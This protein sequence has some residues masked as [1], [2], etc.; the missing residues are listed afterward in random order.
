MPRRRVET[1]YLVEHYR[2]GTTAEELVQRAAGIQEALRVLGSQGSAR[3]LGS[4]AVPTDEAFLV[5]IAAPSEQQVQD[6]Y[7]RI[8]STYDRVSVAVA[9]LAP[10]G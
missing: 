5:L 6:A 8:G 10:S 9:D 4:V 7:V 1:T 2:P 3:F